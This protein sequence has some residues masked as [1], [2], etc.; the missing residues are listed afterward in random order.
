MLRMKDSTQLCELADSLSNPQHLNYGRYLSRQQLKAQVA[1]GLVERS[2]LKE[3]FQSYGMQRLSSPALADQE[4]VFRTTPEQLSHA[5]GSR[6]A[7]NL[8]SPQPV[9]I[10]R[11]LSDLPRALSDCIHT[12]RAIPDLDPNEQLAYWQLKG[13]SIFS[14]V[15]PIESVEDFERLSS[16]AEGLTPCDVQKGYQLPVGINGKGETIAIM[17]LG[18]PPQ[19]EDLSHFW[20]TFKCSTP[21]VNIVQVTPSTKQSKMQSENALHRWEST[22]VVQWLGAIASNA[23]IVLYYINPALVADPWSTFLLA[24]VSDRHFRPTIA[25]TTWS[26]PEQQYYR[27]HSSTCFSTLLDQCAA[28]GITT[29]TASGDWG[30]GDGPLCHAGE[31][32]SASRPGW[33]RAVFPAAEHRILA[34]GGTQVVSLQPWE[35]EAWSAPLSARLQ[36]ALGLPHMASS[37]GFSDRHEIPLW[38]KTALRSHYSRYGQCS[39]IDPYGRGYPDVAL[40]AWGICR[41]KTCKET[42]TLSYW[43]FMD[44]WYSDAGGTSLAAP[45]WAAII[46]IINQMRVYRSLPRLGFSNPL[47]YQIKQSELNCEIERMALQSFRSIT[48]GHTDTYLKTVSQEGKTELT[49]LPGFN[50]CADVWNPV[51]GLGVP[52]VSTLLKKVLEQIP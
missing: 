17:V 5:L 11:I 32:D 24:V 10:A 20:H 46:A 51:A 25:C 36:K 40:A 43:G 52:N 34:V 45:I 37:S 30:V 2:H 49:L 6:T 41:Q 14:Q 18:D 22:M 35:E 19:P 23:R 38:Q 50:A 39:N 15:P 8:L 13:N 7:A 16:A 48:K 42:E 12:V 27:I 9:P 21:A 31:D 47:F 26:A 1:S 29:I 4:L 33:P 3:W 28:L 44:R